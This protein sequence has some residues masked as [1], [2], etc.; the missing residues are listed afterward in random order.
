M[1]DK[2]L[3]AGDTAPACSVWSE[4]GSE[5]RL[6]DL[7]CAECLIGVPDQRRIGRLVQVRKWCGQFGSHIYIIRLANGELMTFENVMI[8]HYGDKRFEDAFYR[9]NGRVPP[10]VRVSPPMA[11]DSDMAEYTIGGKWPE[12]GFVVG[13]PSQPQTPG[14]FALTIITHDKT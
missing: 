13:S 7:V 10:S 9:S 12:S 11:C 5:F 8:R 3:A 14:A 4:G 6:N 2:T 1:D